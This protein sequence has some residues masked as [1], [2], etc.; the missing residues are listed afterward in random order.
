MAGKQAKILTRQQVRA[1][2]RRARCNAAR[3]CR[4]VRVLACLPAIAPAQYSSASMTVITRSVTAGSL[5][6]GE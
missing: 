5:A 6:S 1:A 2:L 4:R 3:T